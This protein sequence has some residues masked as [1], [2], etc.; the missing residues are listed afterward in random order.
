MINFTLIHRRRLSERC[1]SVRGMALTAFI[2]VLLTPFNC[3]VSR[4]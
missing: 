4:R 3:R 2:L 1:E